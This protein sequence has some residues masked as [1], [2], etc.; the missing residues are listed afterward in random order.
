MKTTKILA[1]MFAV[2]MTA[3]IA[4]P[5]SASAAAKTKVVT[6]KAK[7]SG[8]S[9]LLIENSSVKILSVDGTGSAS[10]VGAGSISG[11]GNGTGANG[12][13]VPF[14]GKGK[15]TGSTG[16]ISFSVNV[17]K[18]QGCSSGQSGPV[19]VA[20]TGTIKV[21]G[22]SGKA[23]G[24]SG[25]LTFKGKLKLNDTSGSQS[26]TFSGSLSGNLTVNK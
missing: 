13:C 14:K 12:L 18:S 11:T 6:F 19:T 2:A 15:I 22:G 23:K 16:T 20:V 25:T 4:L 3:L 24:A 5:A 8:T 21:T 7:Y 17:T 9:S 1:V 26:G 10:V